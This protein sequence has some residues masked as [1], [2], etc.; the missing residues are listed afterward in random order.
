MMHRAGRPPAVSTTAAAHA[1]VATVAATAAGS[2]NGEG[3]VHTSPQCM[4]ATSAAT[5]R[6]GARTRVPKSPAIVSRRRSTVSSAG[7]TDT[8]NSLRSCCSR[9]KPS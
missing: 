3:R 4:L 8:E 5:A 7:G 9:R 6:A 1:S 2:T